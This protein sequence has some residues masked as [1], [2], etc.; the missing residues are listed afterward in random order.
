M[1]HTLIKQVREYA[2]PVL[3]E[4]K[5]FASIRLMEKSVSC[6]CANFICMCVLLTGMWERCAGGK[7]VS[8]LSSTYGKKNINESCHT[9]EWVMSHIYDDAREVLGRQVRENALQSLWNKNESCLTYERVTSYVWMSHVTPDSCAGGKFVRMLSSTYGKIYEWVMSHIRMNESCH[10]YEWVMSHIY[11]DA[12]KVRRRK[13]RENALQYVRKKNNRSMSHVTH[14]NESCHT[15]MTTLQRCAGGKFVRML[16]RIYGEKKWVMS[17]VW[18]SHGI[19]MH[20][21]YHARNV[22]RKQLRENAF[23]YLWQK[24]SHVAHMNESCHTYDWV[25]FVVMVWCVSLWELR[26]SWQLLA[27]GNYCAMCREY[28]T[29]WY[30]L[31]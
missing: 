14:T 1:S 2:S 9:H 8:M 27:V 3:M 7:F 19:R 30:M 5:M 13:V 21:S 6:M 25:M 23:Q 12:T 31:S 29:F 16:T 10:T 17:H 22:R 24:N 11:D 18:M 20:E 26:G 15:Y 28:I 4:K